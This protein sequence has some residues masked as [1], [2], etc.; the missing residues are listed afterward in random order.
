MRILVVGSGG[1]EHAICWKI[2]QSKKLIKLYCAPGNG[3][4]AAIAESIVIR[5]DDIAELLNF[6]KT[7][8]ID[9]TVV[10]PEA[11]LVNGIVDSFKREEFKIFGPD[12]AMA[13]LEGSKIFAKEAMERFGLPTAGFKAFDDANE[14]KAFIKE[15]GLPLVIKADGLCAGKGVIIAHI[16]K[17]ALSAIDSLMSDKEFG[18]AGE[19]I[20]IEDCLAGEE[21]SI[22][23]ASDGKDFILFPSSQDHKRAL[24]NDQ[25]PNTGGMGAYSPAP[26]IDKIL[27][28]KI[29]TR[30]IQP[31]I[32]G[33]YKEGTPYKGILYIGLMIADNEP[34]VL[35]FNVRFG[36][37]ETQAILPRLK[38]DLL[39]IIEASLNGTIG[40]ISVEID[41][42]VCVSVVCASEGYPGS[43]KKNLPIE[44]LDNA[45]KVNDVILFH[46][47]TKLAQNVTG[48]KGYET[49]GGRVLAVTAIADNIKQ[50]IDRAYEAVSLIH[51]NGMQYRKDIGFKALERIKN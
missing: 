15:K 11:A 16:E 26:V 42:R 23:L 43:Y 8:N 29:K 36:D 25:G 6:V 22:I 47:G 4:I 14:A 46:A 44:G 50:A 20:L 30:V 17:E 27:E 35:E 5:A 45:L 49:N 7:N 33:L 37:P 28:A 32:E 38:T 24:D 31:I 41:K 39:D 21:A 12:Q 19:R 9:I 18:P 10:G 2:A 34:Y 1:R 13:M 51:F 3:E 40:E 48:A